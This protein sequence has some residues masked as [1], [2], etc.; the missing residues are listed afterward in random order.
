MCVRADETV[1]AMEVHN[2]KAVLYFIAFHMSKTEDQRPLRRHATEMPLYMLYL[3]Y[4]VAS[5]RAL[6]KPISG[7]GGVNAFVDPSLELYYAERGWMVAL[8]VV[9]DV[10]LHTSHPTLRRS[11]P[12]AATA[13]SLLA[14]HNAM[15]YADRAS[16]SN[17]HLSLRDLYMKGTS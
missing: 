10:N 12:W 14:Y 8:D 13:D 11:R 15:E 3:L 6:I 5:Q 4:I 16:L 1:E 17:D 2:V 9:K 7:E